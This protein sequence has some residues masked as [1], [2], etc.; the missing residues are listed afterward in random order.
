[1]GKLT[2]PP[3]Q[4]VCVLATAPRS[5][6][7]AKRLRNLK[8][9]TPRIRKESHTKSHR[10]YIVRLGDDD[11]GALFQLFYSTVDTFHAKTHVMPSRGIVASMKIRVRWATL[12]AG[13]SQKLKDELIVAGGGEKSECEAG[14]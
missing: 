10:D 14:E 3:P 12:S 4:F 6:A 5:A 11:H 9:V 8:K 2:I 13:P 7:T 1:M